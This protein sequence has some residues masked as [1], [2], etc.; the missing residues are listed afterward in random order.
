MSLDFSLY[1]ITDRTQVPPGRTLLENVHA[2]LDGGV[3]GVQLREKDLDARD[4]YRLALEVRRL[5]ERYEARLLINDRADIALAVGADGVHLG[6]TSLPVETVRRLV[7]PERL[8]GASTHSLQEISQAQEGGADFVTFGPVYF[9]PSKSAYGPPVGLEKLKA[10]CAGSALPV[11]AL[12]GVNALRIPEV[13][14]AG[15]SGV[16]LISAVL[17]SYDPSFAASAIIESLKNK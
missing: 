4:L 9:T 7:G 14:A 16:A 11:F 2:A 6:G 5:T 8:I 12:G 1:L 13:M 10:A 17:A 15:A 3:K